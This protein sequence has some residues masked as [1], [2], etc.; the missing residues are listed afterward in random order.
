ML[1][2]IPPVA[3]WLAA[4]LALTGAQAAAG[5]LRLEDAL[6]S[7]RFVAYTPCGF[8]PGA[9]GP[10]PGPEALRADLALLRSHFDGLI[11]YSSANG[12]DRLPRLAREAGFR[13]VV[14]GVWSPGNAEE[15]GRAIDAARAEPGVVVALALGNEGLF[16]HRYGSETLA[17]AFARA[18]RELPGVALA[19][20]E[21]FSLYLDSGQARSLP[22][23]DLL[24]P[25]VHPVDQPWFGSAPPQASVEFVAEVV[26]KL[27]ARFALPVLVKETG[28]PSGPREAGFDPAAQAAFWSALARRLP[29]TRAH[30]FAFFEA[31]D[32]PWKPAR[33]PDP[34][35]AKREREAHWGMFDAE[36]RPKPV[37]KA[38]AP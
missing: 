34:S 37:V 15:L 7:V 6:A 10:P 32:G 8:D 5:A 35:A 12:L 31:F 21:P 13:A 38:L 26:A 11:T 17:S 27:E 36:R 19:T 4:V 23:Q 22:G 14:L 3:R 18:R 29:P 1:R 28:L 9:G 25:N 20:S 24:L 16:F 30:A 33:S 2:A